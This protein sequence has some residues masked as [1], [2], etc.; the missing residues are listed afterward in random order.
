MVLPASLRLARRRAT[1]RALGAAL[2]G[3]PIPTAVGAGDGILLVRLRN[4][5]VIHV[6][7]A[8]AML[9]PELI[10][11]GQ[12]ETKVEAALHRLVEPGQT[13][14]EAGANLGVHSLTIAERVGP[15]GRLHSIEPNPHLAAL[16]RRSLMA[17]RLH[18]RATL[19]QAALGD[20]DGVATLWID[21]HSLGGASTL[22]RAPQSHPVQQTVPLTRLDTLL[23]GTAELHGLRMDIE[24][25]EALALAGAREV[26]ARSPRAWV[27]LEWLPVVMPGGSQGP[28]K[29][30]ETLQAQG[31]RHL[32]LVRPDGTGE[33]IE[34]GRL[35]GVASA[36]VLARR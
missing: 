17:N 21:P 36:E 19:H 30:I 20:H 3:R 23:A 4:G 28:A 15:S 24:G 29:L 8:D 25:A 34:A 33:P 26:L 11:R 7:T 35:L 32:A 1:W 2:R 14:A 6:D 13:I 12:W 9:A 16:L 22:W 10:H 27:L 31:F 18:A 5:R